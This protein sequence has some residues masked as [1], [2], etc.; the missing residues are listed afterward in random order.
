MLATNFK[1]FDVEFD[2]LEILTGEDGGGPERG[3]LVV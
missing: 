1:K 2:Q 3:G